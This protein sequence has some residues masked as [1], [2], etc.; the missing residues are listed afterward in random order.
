MSD[1]ETSDAA[2]EQTTKDVRLT[3][4]VD[5]SLADRLEAAAEQLSRETRSEVT[6]SSLIRGALAHRV[7]EILAA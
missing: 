1:K 6:V 2:T 4:R 5:A 7:E 3:I